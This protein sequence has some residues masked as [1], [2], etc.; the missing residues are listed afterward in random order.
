MEFHDI[1]VT[2]ECG[3]TPKRV[4]D[5]TRIYSQLEHIVKNEKKFWKYCWKKSEKYFFY[6]EDMG[7]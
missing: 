7:F 1:Q 5:M 2:I 4:C 3:F 6:V